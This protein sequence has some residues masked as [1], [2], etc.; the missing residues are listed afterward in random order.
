MFT[1]VSASTTVDGGLSATA[2][3]PPCPPGLE[4]TAGGFSFNGS[5]QA[6]FA[7]G[8]INFDGTWS[9]TGFGYFGQ[10]P[11]LTAYGYCLPVSGAA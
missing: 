6:F 8:S 11:T 10:A 3:T 4:L 7:D 2:T 1:E 5:Q 9:A